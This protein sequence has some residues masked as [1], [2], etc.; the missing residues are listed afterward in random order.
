MGTVVASVL[1]LVTVW[2]V[3]QGELL[4][5]AAGL[6]GDQ[7]RT[8]AGDA[9]R[10]LAAALFGPQFLVLLQQ[11]GIMGAGLAAL[12][13]VTAATFAVLGLRA[14]ASSNRSRA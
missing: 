11:T 14:L 4:A 1:T 13:F 9:A 3:A 5:L 2:L 8:V 10:E 12:G 6:A 7:V